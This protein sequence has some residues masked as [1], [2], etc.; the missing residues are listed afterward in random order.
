M[1]SNFFTATSVPEWRVRSGL[2]TLKKVFTSPQCLVHHAKRTIS[3]RSTVELQLL[4]CDLVV[5]FQQYFRFSRFAQLIRWSFFNLYSYNLRFSSLGEDFAIRLRWGLLWFLC[6]ILFSLLLFPL[7]LVVLLVFPFLFT[8]LALIV[9]LCFLWPLRFIFFQFLWGFR[10]CNKWLVYGSVGG[11]WQTFSIVV[12][13]WGSS[14]IFYQ[15][16]PSFY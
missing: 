10:S 8:T 7:L 1:T 6:F 12:S 16:A 4:K 11:R 9:F 2:Q 15:H 13:H 14:C 3:K 5:A